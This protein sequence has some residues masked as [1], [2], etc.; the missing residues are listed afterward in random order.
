MIKNPK[1]TIYIIYGLV[2][3]LEGEE[4]VIGGIQKYILGLVEV[5]HQ[6]YNIIIIQSAKKDFVKE[7]KTYKVFGF[8]TNTKGNIGKELFSKIK[9]KIQVSDYII[10]GTDRIST[11][12]KHKNVIAIQHGI[13]FD[14]IDYGSIKIGSLL[15]KSLFLSIIYRMFQQLSAVKYFLRTDKVICV[16]YNFLN[17]VR[18]VLPRN[19]TKRA[20]VIPNYSEIPELKPKSK[21]NKPIKVLFA[22]RF[23]EYRGVYILS[24]IIENYVKQENEIEFGVYGEGP[25]EDFLKNKFQKFKNVK[26]SSYNPNNALETLLK[27][28][29]SIIPTI[30]S[31]GTSLSLLES[32]ACGCV[33]IATN[34]GGMTNVVIDGYNGFL[35]NPIA[36]EFCEKIDYLIKNKSEMEELSNNA[37]LSVEKGFSFQIWKKKW[38]QVL[39]IRN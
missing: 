30:G 1:P 29:I 23:V 35:V 18:T 25:L 21:K 13:T 11:K 28:D 15:K 22:R 12:I 32:M 7:F 34:V 39:K 31:E 4:I 38:E 37:R 3:D 6:K 20:V 8:N 27:Y 36:K 24:E 19:L 16:D 26:I 33:P 17:W 5:F 2:L 14:F 9:A 10:W